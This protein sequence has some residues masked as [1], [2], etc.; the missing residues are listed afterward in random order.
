MSVGCLLSD[1][2]LKLILLEVGPQERVAPPCSV[3]S[4]PVDTAVPPRQLILPDL[5][6]KHSSGDQKESPMHPSQQSSWR[7]YRGQATYAFVFSE[8]Q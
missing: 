5:E 8:S 1:T 6:G 4:S 2:Q 3:S 7:S